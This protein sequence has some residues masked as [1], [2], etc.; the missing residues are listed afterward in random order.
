[1]RRNH[2]G[3]SGPR[4]QACRFSQQTVVIRDE[5]AT[6]VNTV[7]GPLPVSPLMDPAF[8][9]ARSRW[10]TPKPKRCA[11]KKTTWQNKL[12][13]NPLGIL[14][15]T[16]PNS[17]G[18]SLTLAQLMPWHHRFA[19]ARA[20]MYS[21]LATSCKASSSFST[22]HPA[23]VGSSLMTSPP[24]G[25]SKGRRRRP[26]RRG[27]CP[28]RNRP[29]GAPPMSWPPRHFFLASP[30]TETPTKTDTSDSSR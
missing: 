11:F 24:P 2:I 22:M 1:M 20:H 16:P 3:A 17:P 21:C 26:H 23:D 29:W 14:V 13:R 19:V 7:A 18:G 6:V 5:A 25:K 10:S 28:A 12:A 4:S 27:L 15:P 30:R 9:H 8:V